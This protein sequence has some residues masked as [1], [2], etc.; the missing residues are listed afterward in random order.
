MRT[1]LRVPALAVVAALATAPAAPARTPELNISLKHGSPI[2]QRKK[3]QIE[4][5]AAQYDLGRFTVTRDIRIEEGARSHSKPVL[6]LNCRYL[7]DDDLALSVYLHEQGHWVLGEHRRE[8]R[9]L[10]RDLK[11]A[12]PGLP[13]QPPAGSGGERDSY[14][15]LAVILL[16]WQALEEVIGV[17]RARAA[18]EFKQTRNYTALFR[19]VLERRSTVE[20]ILGRYRVRW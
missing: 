11:R 12:F 14:L 1:R 13:T 8:I 17:K 10:Y 15:H 7:R 4:K 5:L 6:T 18:E 2:E 20:D 9:D 16:E 19:T 3:E